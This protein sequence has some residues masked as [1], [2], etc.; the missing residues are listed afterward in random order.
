MK[1][2]ARSL[3]KHPPLLLNWFRA[4]G[5]MSSGTVEG[6]NNKARLILR[7]AYGFRTYR[8]MEVALYMHLALY[9]SRRPP[10]DFADEAFFYKG[11]PSAAPNRSDKD[12]ARTRSRGA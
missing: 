11:G 1:K 3:R 5:T 9:P 4:K 8:G 2:I 10:T 6:F 7:R 12:I